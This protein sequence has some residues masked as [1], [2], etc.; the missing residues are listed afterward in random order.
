VTTTA[1]NQS[2]LVSLANRVRGEVRLGL[3]DRLLYATD[4]S[5]Y[6]V[7]PI[8]VVIPADLDDAAEAVR[9]VAGLGL[10]ILPRGGGTSLAGQCV[11]EAVVLDLSAF[12]R[13]V[14]AIDPAARRCRAEAGVTIEALNATLKPTGLF[15]APD[16]ATVRQA[17]VGGCIGNNAAG[18]RSIRYGR[19]SESVAGVEVCLAD[20]RRVKFEAGAGSRDPVAA[21]LARAVAR[22]VSEH[23]G[24]IRAR[25]PRT[26]RRNAGYGLDMILD[27]LE[28]GASPGELNLAPLIC[29]S[30]GTLAVTL[31]ADLLL[32]PIPACTGLAVASFPS[33][34]EAIAMVMPL[35]GLNPSAVEL[36]DSMIIRL[37]RENLEQRRHVELLPGGGDAEAVL[38]I[39][40]QAHDAAE[41]ARSLDAVRAVLPEGRVA[42]HTDPRAMDRAW[43]LR[44]AG[45]PL[46]HGIPGDRKPVG[47]IEDAAVPPERLGEYVRRLREIVEREG[48]I[49]SYYAHASVG[50]LHVRPLLDLRDPGDRDAMERIALGSADLARE[51]G[52]VMSGEHGDGRARGPLLERFYGPELMEAFRRVKSAFDPE[53]RL[54]PGNIVAPGPIGTIHQKTR[55]TA[56]RTHHV[57]Q[58][59]YFDF[60][61]EGGIAHAAA[62]CNGAGVC[63]KTAGGT[64][65][66]SFRGTLDERHAT[67]GR[68]NALRLAITGQFGGA[69]RWDDPETMATLDLCLSCKAC[70]SECPSNV[71]IAKLKAEYTAQGHLASG[72]VPLKAR[73]FGNIHA[74]NRLAGLAPGLANLGMK[75][76]RPAANALLGLHAARSLPEYR[77]PL[78]RRW[79]STPR[80]GAGDKAR[81]RP[82]VALYA[83]TFTAC[84][85]PGVGLA[86]KR[87]LEAFGYR[88][89]LFRGSDAARAQIS[90][91]LL[92]EAIR[93]IDRETRAL[94]PVLERVEAVLFLEPSCLSAVKDDWLAL[95][96]GTPLADRRRLADRSFL[97]EQF[98]DE[99]WSDH[100][101]RP[102]VSPAAPMPNAEGG[103]RSG[104]GGTV[105]TPDAIHL[106]AHCHQKAL[107]GA[108]S[109]ANLLERLFPGRVRVLDTTCCGLAGSFGYTRERFD[110]SM[111]IGELGVL[112]AARGLKP[113]EVLCAPGTSCRHQVKDGAGVRALHPVEVVA[114][115]LTEPGP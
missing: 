19:T 38:Y 59:T 68:G 12:C 110:L 46:L 24:P 80:A 49:A 53:N 26:R 93:R 95:K 75:L 114:A 50:V 31:V 79:G 15:F 89:E 32:Y 67:R 18:S 57:S 36:L 72:R 113:G 20:G 22:V 108:G 10:P 102:V 3:H 25:F 27:Q 99:R 86:A 101:V 33:V 91:G 58:P 35:L 66:P 74:I 21:E 106:H 112:P 16:P 11:N 78:H 88:V 44:K 34:D 111:R 40:F 94:L 115:R 105:A 62:L 4:A 52:G 41:L 42:C 54:N 98:L 17:T 51:L 23:A 83:D 69:P 30:E 1:N 29:G 56:E 13:G 64:M 9:A 48:T 97:V 14:S 5:I 37:A 8:G 87:V 47:F 6:Q 90:V 63:R 104:P 60:D 61:A 2:R 92:A 96:A 65:C 107:W 71:D 28:T 84:N 70:K 82:T 81:T 45:E 55:L 103:P 7:E 85:E 109:S 100:P 39:E 77:T 43:G 76:T 73:V